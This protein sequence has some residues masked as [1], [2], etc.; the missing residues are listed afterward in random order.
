MLSDFR[1]DLDKATC[2][3]RTL[4]TMS[5][6]IAISLKIIF[7]YSCSMILAFT[8]I[9]YSFPK[10]QK[11]EQEHKHTHTWP[12]STYHI[13][14]IRK[15]DVALSEWRQYI[16]ALCVYYFVQFWTWYM[17]YAWHTREGIL[18][19]VQLGW[20]YT[21]LGVGYYTNLLFIIRLAVAYGMSEVFVFQYTQSKR[22][23][24]YIYV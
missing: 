5:H 4:G 17:V 1:K 20:S 19:Y 12:R 22:I 16:Y 9:S 24:V 3:T 2:N 21:A 15:G 14:Y 23:Y 8:R 18:K 13:D 7:V 11:H 10:D 6:R